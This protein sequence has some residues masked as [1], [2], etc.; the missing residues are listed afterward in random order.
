MDTVLEI[1]KYTL[2]AVVVLVGCVVIIRRFLLADFKEKQLNL[3]R[4]NQGVTV[5][6]RLQAYERLA[7]FLE[8]I[9][10]RQMIPRLYVGNMTVSE[11][12]AAIIINIR[13][14]YEHN[15]SQQIYV[16]RQVW[17]AVRGVKEQEINMVGLIAKQLQPTA[18]AR[19][20][21]QRIADYLLTV[22]EMP[23]ETALQV[24]NEEA[25]RVLTYG[26]EA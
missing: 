12:E 1:L 5:R 20:L 26:A 6:L 18:P 4:D 17:N 25:K 24:V 16:S 14:E 22:E 8:R 19:E 3:L 23:I 9:H 10:P 11:L 2:P 21:H 15:L 7:L 13:A